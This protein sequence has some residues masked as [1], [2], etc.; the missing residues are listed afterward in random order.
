MDARN[1]GFYW[2]YSLLLCITIQRIIQNFVSFF[3]LILVKNAMMK[4]KIFFKTDKI[5]FNTSSDV[6]SLNLKKIIQGL[7]VWKRIRE[8]M[9][10]S[11]WKKI[12]QHSVTA[13]FFFIISR[14]KHPPRYHLCSGKID[15]GFNINWKLQVGSTFDY[16]F[17]Q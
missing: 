9:I 8:Y 17:M 13:L 7:S 11:V 14:K 3:F 6:L 16:K 1:C 12:K 15:S 2:Q 5:I 4:W 10:S